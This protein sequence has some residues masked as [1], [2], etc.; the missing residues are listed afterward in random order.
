MDSQSST[1]T[2]DIS[3]R[4]RIG[5]GEIEL[6]NKLIEGAS[7]L[8]KW[9]SGLERGRRAEVQIMYYLLFFIF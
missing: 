3:N 6:V 1:G 4:D 7:E 2:W 5:K 9:E 8:V